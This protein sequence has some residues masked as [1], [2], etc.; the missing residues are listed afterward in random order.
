MSSAWV[1]CRPRNS[2]QRTT[3]HRALPRA[4]AIRTKPLPPGTCSIQYT[5][6]DM[7]MRRIPIREVEVV[8]DGENLRLADGTE[9]EGTVRLN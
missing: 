9:W 5:V 3:G 2:R 6:V 8:R 4:P 1:I 7:F